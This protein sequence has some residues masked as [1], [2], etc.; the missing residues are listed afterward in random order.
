MKNQAIKMA[1]LVPILAMPLLVLAGDVNFPPSVQADNNGVW[2]AVINISNA[3]D[4]MFEIL[5]TNNTVVPSI[6][7]VDLGGGKWKVTLGG[8]LIDPSKNGLVRFR[9][10]PEG[11]F[12]EGEIIILPHGAMPLDHFKCYDVK[13]EKAKRIKVDLEDQFGMERRVKVS[14]EPKMLCNPVIK[15]HNDEEFPVLNPEQH[16]VCYKIKPMKPDLRVIVSNQFGE[17][18]ELSVGKSKYL[19]LPSKKFIVQSDD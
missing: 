17:K 13:G 9:A 7:I 18:Q 4:H 3:E 16:L 2:S 15:W 12:I 14:L 5:G 1:L 6:N 11:E 10:D 19:C 8:Q